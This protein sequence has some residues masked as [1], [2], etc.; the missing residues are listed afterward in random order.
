VK[1]VIVVKKS[2]P[3]RRIVSSEEVPADL[4]NRADTLRDPVQPDL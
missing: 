1:E 3:A 4:L 2:K